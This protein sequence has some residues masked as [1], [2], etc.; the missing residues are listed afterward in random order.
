MTSFPRI[1]GGAGPLI[2]FH[3]DQNGNYTVQW[4]KWWGQ[5]NYRGSQSEVPS[6]LGFKYFFEVLLL[7]VP[8]VCAV[9]KIDLLNTIGRHRLL[10]HVLK[11]KER[12]GFRLL[13]KDPE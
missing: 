7:P 6:I 2:V 12:W 1:N 9:S 3:M 11:S 13:Q 10:L 8:S 4:R 5:H